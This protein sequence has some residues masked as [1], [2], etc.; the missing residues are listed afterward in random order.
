M[1]RYLWGVRKLCKEGIGIVCGTN[2]STSTSRLSPSRAHV[3]EPLAR[4]MDERKP[5]LSMK[6]I[7]RCVFYTPL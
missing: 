4:V 1:L 7:R 5:N 3:R 6:L 2:S